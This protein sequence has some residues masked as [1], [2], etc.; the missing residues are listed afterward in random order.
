MLE[1]GYESLKE[2]CLGYVKSL[3]VVEEFKMQ[4]V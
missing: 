3:E 2:Q 4:E 1:L